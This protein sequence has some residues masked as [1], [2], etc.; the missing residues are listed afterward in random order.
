MFESANSLVLPLLGVGILF[1]LI[2]F[3]LNRIYW[4]SSWVKIAFLLVIVGSLLS[5]GLITGKKYFSKA[6]FKQDAN[7]IVEKAVEDLDQEIIVENREKEE[8][9]DKAE[10]LE[11]QIEAIIK[12]DLVETKEKIRDKSNKDFKKKSKFQ[13][14]S[15]LLELEAYEMLVNSRKKFM[16]ADV[17]A[18]EEGSLDQATFQTKL[19]KYKTDLDSLK[20]NYDLAQN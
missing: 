13:K 8:L 4:L 2:Y 15:I 19:E 10:N 5:A 1:T 11:Q 12:E 6:N 3:L 17:N 7:N 9:L 20:S 14:D 16:I 18:F